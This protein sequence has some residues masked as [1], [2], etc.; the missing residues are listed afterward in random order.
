MLTHALPFPSPKCRLGRWRA[1][2][3]LQKEMAETLGTF[4]DSHYSNAMLMALGRAAEWKNAMYQLQE[5]RRAK[6]EGAP[7]QCWPTS[8]SYG[9]VITAC[10]RAG[11]WSRALDILHMMSE[12][13]V[14]PTLIIFNSAMSACERARQWRPCMELLE[15]A[16]AEPG[17]EPDVVSCKLPGHLIAVNAHCFPVADCDADYVQHRHQR[18]GQGWPDGDGLAAPE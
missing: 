7:A 9:H 2:R 18:L 4:P 14:A 12:D 15:K 5:M 8:S 1:A 11:E 6:R 10:G 17:V 13:K 16:I 3:M